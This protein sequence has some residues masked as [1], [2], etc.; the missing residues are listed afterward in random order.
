M[1]ER[2]RKRNVKN[3]ILPFIC[4]MILGIALI[5]V[6]LVPLGTLI[7]GPVAFEELRPDD[8]G[9]HLFVKATIDMSY[10]GYAEKKMQQSGSSQNK[11]T[12]FYYVIRTGN[13]DAEYFKYMGIGVGPYL[14]TRMDDM[15]ENT[16]RG[17]TS[18]PV[19]VEG[20][21]RRM[22]LDEKRYFKQAFL[23]SGWKGQD[24]SKMTLPYVLDTVNVTREK[25]IVWVVT[26]AGVGILI[27]VPL[28]FISIVKGA[29]L[30]ALKRDI[31]MALLTED[32][33]E[34][35]Y[36]EA[37]CCLKKPP[38]YIG[39]KRIFYMGNRQPR[40]FTKDKI[41]WVYQHKKDVQVRYVT[42]KT[43]YSVQIRYKDRTEGMIL[44][45]DSGVASYVEEALQREMPWVVAGYDAEL[46]RMYSN[47]MQQFLTL[48]YNEYMAQA[49]IPA[50][51]DPGC[52]ED[53][54]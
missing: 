17:T 8:I 43:I 30:S 9:P 29:G 6:M 23:V 13:D 54:I 50:E 14:G 4:A 5:L 24:I 48:R 45:P 41:V 47:N 10:G 52:S 22:T 36:L 26:G 12:E 2:L 51:N 32:E 40:M 37:R 20:V 46:N 19:K 42:V 28:W 15:S 44:V 21:I 7:K 1:L 39:D 38:I 18:S 11:S 33:A 31:R 3:A 27:L 16:Y 49:S 53:L 35:E 25:T 34:R